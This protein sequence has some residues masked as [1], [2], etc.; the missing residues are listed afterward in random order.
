M[1]HQ[2]KL[3]VPSL[4]KAILYTGVVVYFLASPGFYMDV[5]LLWFDITN[6]FNESYNRQELGFALS[7]ENVDPIF[8]VMRVVSSIG[9][10]L[11]VVGLIGIVINQFM[12]KK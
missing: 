10:L 5:G 2:N 1:P 6:L 4:F 8:T 9:L 11:A 12:L 3:S 7:S